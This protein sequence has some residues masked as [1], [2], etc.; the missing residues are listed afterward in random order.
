[1]KRTWITALGLLLATALLV[2]LT[3]TAYAQEEK[4]EEKKS[5]PKTAAAKEDRIHGVVQM[6]SKDTSTITVR[7]TQTNATRQIVYTPDTKVTKLNKA[8]GS[9]EEIKEGS[10]IICLGKFDEKGR[11]VAT[12]CD[13]RSPK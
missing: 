12:R 11:L 8:G 9:I 3:A 5:R 10:N 1:M 6:I 7:Q 13:I 4:K 2:G